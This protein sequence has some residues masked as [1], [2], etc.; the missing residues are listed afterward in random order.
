MS[1]FPKRTLQGTTVTIHWNFNT[2]HITDGHVFPY[3]RIGVQAPDGK[4]TMLFEQYVLGFPAIKAQQK[5]DKKQLL[6]LN[7]NTPLLVLADYLS[8]HHKREVLVNILQHI[9]NGRHYYF[10]YTVPE[11]APP[12]K[13]T[14]ISEVYNNGSLK[15]S[16]T[17]SDDFFFVER[18]TIDDDNIVNHSTEKTPVKIVLYRPDQPINAEEVQV[19]EMQPREA[20]PVS[21]FPPA[22]CF[23]IYN[24]ERVIIPLTSIGNIRCI[25]NQQ[26]LC[27]AKEDTLHIL[28]NDDNV[29]TLE[30]EAKNIWEKA[31]GVI[32]KNELCHT[33]NISIYQEM[34]ENKLIIEITTNDGS[35]NT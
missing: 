32:T 21:S 24:E 25:R 26:A 12:G 30:E 1:I 23:L 29:Y 2:A 15:H 5:S 18:I 31:N 8:T 14:L 17:A 27:L 35:N 10:H 34:V 4:I 20:I 6:Y 11:N 19:F 9:Q 33:G 7:K 28:L 13:Y 3:V 22:D 16:T